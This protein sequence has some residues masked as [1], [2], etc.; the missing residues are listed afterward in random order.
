MAFSISSLGSEEG[1]S[2]HGSDDWGVQN[3]PPPA[4]L[5]LRAPRAEGALQ[6]SDSKIRTL[7]HYVERQ[8]TY[9]SQ[10]TE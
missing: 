5:E 2:P 4:R 7:E 6:A 9:L 1:R 3:E 10:P 8:Q